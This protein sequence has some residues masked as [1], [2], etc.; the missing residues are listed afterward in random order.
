MVDEVMWIAVRLADP[1]GYIYRLGIVSAWAFFRTLQGAVMRHRGVDFG[2]LLVAQKAAGEAFTAE[3]EEVLMPFAAI[4]ASAIADA[5]THHSER[6]ARADSRSWPGPRQSGCR[7]RGLAGRCRSAARHRAPCE[8]RACSA[9]RPSGPW[10]A[11]MSFRRAAKRCACARE[12][13]V[14]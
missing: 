1:P 9:V 2:T 13:V 4:A 14:W 12:A 3:D 6:R 8:T 10:K 11:V 7:M 5:R